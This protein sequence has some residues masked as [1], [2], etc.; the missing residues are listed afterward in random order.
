MGK[1]LVIVESPAKARTIARFL[2][3]DFAVE[4][5]V[6]HIRDLP[7]KASELPPSLRKKSWARLGVD[8]EGDFKPVYVNT[9]RGKEQVK[10]LKDLLKNAPALYLATD[11]DREGEAIAWHLVQALKPKVPVR[12]LVFHEI[13]S[14]AIQ[15]ALDN[16]RELNLDLVKAQET[17]R[18]VDRLVGWDVSPI[19]WRKIRQ[20]LSAGRVQSVAVRLIVDRERTRIAFVSGSWWDLKASFSC[21]EG[22]WEGTLVS[23]NGTRLATSRDFDASTGRPKESAKVL[24]LDEAAARKLAAQVESGQARVSNVERKAFNERPQPPFAT[25]TLQQEA[26]RRFRWTARKTMSVAQRLYENGWITYMRTDSFFLSDQALAAARKAILKEHGNDYLPEKARFY[27]SKAKGAQEAHEAI[28]P[29]GEVFRPTEAC[30]SA[31]DNDCA[32]L[33]D[34]I[35]RRSLA[36]QMVDAQGTR[37]TLDTTVEPDAV[38]FRAK[39]KAYTFPGF[40]AAFVATRDAGKEDE[41]GLLPNVSTGTSTEVTDVAAEG[42]TT[43]PQPR[44]TEATLIKELEARGIG[45]PS[46]YAAILSTIQDR[47]YVFKKGTALVPT[48]T[49]FAVTNLMENH[50]TDLVDY[51]FTARLEDGLDS[52]ALGK[53]DNLLY[54]KDFYKGSGKKD[55]DHPGLVVLLERA[56]AEAKPQELCSFPLGE[57]EGKVLQVRVGRYGPYLQ[58]DDVKRSLPEDLP[59]DELDLKAALEILANVP[60]G[61]RDL[62]VD[63]KSGLGVTLHDGRFGPYV[64]LGEMV[65]KGSKAIKPPRASLLKGMEM[66]S[67]DLETALALLSLPRTL[68]QNAEG[69]DILAFNGRY[70]PYVQAEKV[71]VNLP[72]GVSPLEV[73]LEQALEALANPPKRG[74]SNTVLKELG[75]DGEDR[76]VV[77]RSGRFGPYV[78]DGDVNATVRKGTDPDSVTL[79]QALEMLQ[80]KR[81]NPSKRRSSRKKKATSKKATSKKATGKKATGKKATGKKATRSRS[82]KS[83]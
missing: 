14:R 28:R 9:T 39:G 65:G 72:E 30:V 79:E 73:T 25:S 35:R 81:D 3:A 12:R 17:R 60:E 31:L 37:M 32:R 52:I 24:L 4:A 5:S 22:S 7:N 45:R 53:L 49:A 13:T 43:M 34:L 70:G 50:F 33:Y 77:L 36:C 15:A 40:R 78:T 41:S 42:H 69:K 2:G 66:D 61:P 27:K 62:G 82:S 6:G 64:Q 57:V 38:L 74:R 83:S 55:S 63:A 8:V 19:L 75:K 10:K 76:A 23:V 11:E 26:N 56:Q 16:P 51:D 18:I 71:R 46:T 44:L 54:L 58:H 59:P 47:G 68:G 80:H 20:G 67:V 1:P 48:W 21:Q 29:A